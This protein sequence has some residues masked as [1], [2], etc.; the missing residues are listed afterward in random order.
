MEEVKPKIEE[1][2]PLRIPSTYRFKTGI[3]E[4]DRALN[5][6]IPA[7]LT[8]LVMNDPEN[9]ASTFCQQLCWHGLI[10]DEVCIYITY[11]HHP[12]V[13][14][15]NMLRFGWNVA[16]YEKNEDFIMVDCFSG[17]LGERGGEKYWLEK[18]FDGLS[19]LETFRRLERKIRSSKAGRPVRVIL[20]SF[21]P[22][23]QV[24]GF[25]DTTKIVMKLQ[26]LAKKGIYV[27]VGV[28]HKGIHGKASEFIARHVSEGV[29]EL[30][31][32]EEGGELKQYV[33][34]SKMCLTKF[35]SSKIE[36][37]LSDEGLVSVPKL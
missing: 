5:G 23:A 2:P 10:N 37:T 31:T 16:P 6:G 15:R 11:D 13:V 35:D 18:P 22:L 27:G 19:L 33:R 29:I 7:T 8:V 17:R 4:L 34:V 12:N 32:K 14:R 30:Y 28:V 25:M 3:P 9:D 21:S 24:I 20:D 1:P 36:Y 26:N